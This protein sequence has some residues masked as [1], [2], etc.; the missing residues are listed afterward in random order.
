[1]GTAC[2]INPRAPVEIIGQLEAFMKEQ[3]VKA[4]SD[5]VGAARPATGAEGNLPKV[6]AEKPAAPKKATGETAEY[7]RQFMKDSDR[8]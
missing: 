1:V 7:L 2:F 8:A 3:N 6:G 5:L 4:V